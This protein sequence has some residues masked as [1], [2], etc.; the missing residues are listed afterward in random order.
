MAFA[1]MVVVSSTLP[2]AFLQ[3]KTYIDYLSIYWHFEVIYFVDNN[4]DHDYLMNRQLILYPGYA[5]NC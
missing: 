2:K 3:G 5:S 4:N 1:L